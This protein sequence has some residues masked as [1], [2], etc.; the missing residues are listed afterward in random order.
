MNIT[1]VLVMSVLIEAVISYTKNIFI[2]KKFAW[3]IAVSIFLSVLICLFYGI[4]IPALVGIETNVKYVGS[5]ITGVLVSR[6]S[7][8]I[9]DL[10]KTITQKKGA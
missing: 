3:Q 2:D 5:I 9:N 7:N 6:G 8:Y 10:F 4:D 1:S